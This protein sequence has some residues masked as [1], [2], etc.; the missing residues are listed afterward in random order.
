VC[1]KNLTPNYYDQLPY[2]RGYRVPEFSKFSEEDSKT[3]LEHVGQFILQY[4]EA[5]ANDALRLKM[6]YL[7]LSG[8]AFTWFASLAPNSVFTWA[9]LE[10]KIYEYFYSGDSELRLLYLTVIKQNHNEPVTDYIRRFR[11]TKN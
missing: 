4:G 5:S 6:F 1:T 11:Y 2:P 10:Q 8:T 7:S 9:Q 3:T